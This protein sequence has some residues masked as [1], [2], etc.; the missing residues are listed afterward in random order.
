MFEFR[1]NYK[2]YNESLGE[3]MTVFFCCFFLSKTVKS[4]FDPPLKQVTITICLREV[5]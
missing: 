4:R 1:M 2:K 5:T 3:I